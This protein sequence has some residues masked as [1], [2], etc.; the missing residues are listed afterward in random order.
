MKCFFVSDLHGDIKR[1]QSLFKVITD[2]EPDVVFF[3][4]DLLPNQ[5]M[6][7]NSIEEFLNENI[8]LKIKEIRKKSSK[9]IRF[10]MIM[11]NDDP[12]IFEKQFIKADKDKIIE[13]VNMKTLEIDDFFVTGYSYV[14]PTPFQLKDWERY[15]ISRFVDVGAIS[16]EQG[17]RSIDITNDEA[18]Y[19]TIA[20]DL[21]EL[22]KNS[23]IDK[24]IFL[25][26][27]PPYD[28]NLDR[29]ALD[30]ESYDHAPLDVHIGSIAIQRFIE[31]K[32]PFLTLHGHVHE[33]TSLTGEWK[34]KNGKTFSF[35]A[36]HNSSD[37][38]LVRFDTEDLTSASRDLISA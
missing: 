32:Q 38:A 24:T 29:A 5:Y 21:T 31:K 13:Y 8:F 17:I 12:R 14:P 34:E 22:S 25:F 37:L 11:G 36:A 30:G 19:S 16:P 15:D 28:S 1:Y 35:S 4:G 3:G 6:I 27:S 20:E 9:N 33:S 10:F 23:P 18:R 26:H 2:E 7:K